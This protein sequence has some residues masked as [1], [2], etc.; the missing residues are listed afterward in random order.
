M[1][2][3]TIKSIK[4]FLETLNKIEN[5]WDSVYEEIGRSGLEISDLIHEVELT[6]F[7]PVEGIHLAEEIKKARRHRRELKDYQEVIRHMKEYLDRNKSLKINLFKVLTAMERTREAQ[8]NRTY[9]PRV[10]T[11]LKLCSKENQL[12][13]KGEAAKGSNEVEVE[14]KTE[15]YSSADV[16]ELIEQDTKDTK[17]SASEADFSD[18]R[19]V[20]GDDGP[21]PCRG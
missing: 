15:S 4:N 8:C 3:E 10:R 16:H 7:D 12:N 2:P 9:T 20:V 17:E 11:D 5:N 13:S 1:I 6:D 14:N 21:L 18:D 19:E